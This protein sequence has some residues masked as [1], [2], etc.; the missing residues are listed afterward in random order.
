MDEFIVI[1]K[2]RAAGICTEHIENLEG[3]TKT[4]WLSLQNI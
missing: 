3:Q 2:A 1:Y 4:R